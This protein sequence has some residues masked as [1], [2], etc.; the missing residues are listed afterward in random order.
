MLRS[1]F[2]SAFGV[3]GAIYCLSVAG[4]G[5]RIG[6]KCLI[7][8]KWDYHFQETEG[9]YLR[10]DTLWNLCEAPPHVVPWNV[11]LFSILVVASSLELVLCGIQLVNATFGVLCGDC[12]KKEGAAH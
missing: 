5:L 11:T 3:L 10:N 4:A 8:N 1:V 6:P 7:D 12:R 9:A 2:S